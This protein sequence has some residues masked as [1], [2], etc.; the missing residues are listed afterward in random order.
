MPGYL[1][2]DIRHSMP[3]EMASTGMFRYP[4]S[5]EIQSALTFR[6]SAGMCDYSTPTGIQS[7]PIRRPVKL[8]SH[9]S[10]REA[11]NR[12]PNGPSVRTFLGHR[13]NR[14][15]IRPHPAAHKASSGRVGAQCRS[16]PPV[17]PRLARKNHPIARG[18]AV[19]SRFVSHRINEAS[20]PGEAVHRPGFSGLGCCV[21][22]P[23]SDSVR[24]LRADS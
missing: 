12:A 13:R 16:R 20:W 9:R 1:G 24:T 7:A 4:A 21:P 15:R 19:L 18:L 10:S 3:T 2:G 14:C 22:I 8:D 6:H 5:T 11:R 17:G 23:A